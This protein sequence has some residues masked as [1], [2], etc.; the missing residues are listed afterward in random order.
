MAGVIYLRT[1][2][3]LLAMEP[4]A[5]ELKV[6]RPGSA[7]DYIARRRAAGSTKAEA[8]RSLRRFI[9]EQVYRRMT[10][11]AAAAGRPR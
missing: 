10:L 2:T 11:D 4:R 9:S 5:Y 3:G 6:Q 1:A 7:Q 8:L